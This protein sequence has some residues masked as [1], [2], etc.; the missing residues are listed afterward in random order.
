MKALRTL[1]AAK[2]ACSIMLAASP[3]V[4]QGVAQS[5]CPRGFVPDANVGNIVK[6]DITART[7]I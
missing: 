5:K 3:A 4:A 6:F 2:A 7:D 1:T